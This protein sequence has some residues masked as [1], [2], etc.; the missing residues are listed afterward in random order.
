[1]EIVGGTIIG[2]FYSIY[3]SAS[4]DLGSSTGSNSFRHTENISI[5]NQGYLW[6]VYQNDL[7]RGVYSIIPITITIFPEKLK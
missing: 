2:S 5:K 3:P 6:Q 1:M 7:S 4:G